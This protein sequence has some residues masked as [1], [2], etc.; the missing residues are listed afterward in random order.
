MPAVE[1]GAGFEKLTRRHAVK[2]IP[3]V[4]C[5]V[6]EA[7]LA[8]GEVVGYDSV[9]SASR[10]NGAIII[11][12]VKVPKVNE[13]VESVVVIHD[14]FTPALPLVSPAKKVTIS[15]APPFIKNE[16]LAK[17]LSRYGQLVSPI[18]TVS[19][20]CKSVLLKHV[21]HRRQVFMILKDNAGE[22]NLS[23]TFK[24]EGFN[25]MVFASSESMKCFG[26]GGEGHL[27]RSCPERRRNTQPADDAIGSS[28]G[29]DPAIT[30][31][32]PAELRHS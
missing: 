19:L 21:C 5:S 16:T 7:V 12:L 25:Y 31:A 26:C 23:F 17:E 8:V 13:L 22:L 32:K 30:H 14:T 29:R 27:I 11:F 15:N 1:G 9:K 10:M 20:G 28:P 2:L 3:T 24:I 4:N 18:K 6:E